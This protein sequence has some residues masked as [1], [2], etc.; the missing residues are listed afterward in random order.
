MFK[1][2][3][4]QYDTKLVTQNRNDCELEINLSYEHKLGCGKLELAKKSPASLAEDRGFEFQ[5]L[6]QLY[7][8][9]IIA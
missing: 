9:S 1:C 8:T 6:L 4:Y 2:K 7:I 5:T 3:W